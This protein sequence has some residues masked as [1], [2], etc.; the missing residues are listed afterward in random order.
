M[1]SLVKRPILT[2]AIPTFNRPKVL[3]ES[4]R[5]I[6]TQLDDECSLLIIDNASPIPAREALR[7]LLEE[8]P[9]ANVSIE[10]NAANIGGNSNIMR[11]FEYARCEWLWVV[12]DDDFIAPGSVLT[13]KNAILDAKQAIFLNFV[14]DHFSRQRSF[15]SVGLRSAIEDLDNFGNLL[16]I[17]TSVYRREA[18]LPN[19]RFGCHFTYSCAPHLALLFTSLGDQG[20]VHWRTESIVVRP[21]SDEESSQNFSVIFLGLPTLAELP[22]SQDTRRTLM[23]KIGTH[24]PSLA[25][26]LAFANSFSLQKDREYGRW[27][28]CCI[29]RRILGISYSLIDDLTIRLFSPLLWAPDFCW[30]LIRV[31]A[32]VMGRKL[33]FENSRQSFPR[34]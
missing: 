30:R 1:N 23:R 15:R 29:R 17:S 6:L 25:G 32:R 3:V 18:V 7:S 12:G 11:C 5:R 4:V 26:T 21:N 10:C 19:L 34:L 9:S 14:S 13:V 28:F 22:M 24:G 33:I 8:F 31:L 16:F 2:L 20:E 27:L